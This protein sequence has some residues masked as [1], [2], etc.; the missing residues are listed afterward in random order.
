MSRSLKNSFWLALLVGVGFSAQGSGVWTKPGGGSWPVTGNWL[1]GTVAAGSGS[2]AD[3]STLVLS[4]SPTVTLDGNR[5]IGV[6]I[7]GDVGNTYGW[8]LNPGTGGILTLSG[9]SPTITVSN[10]TTLLNVALDGTNGLTKTGLGRLRLGVSNTLGGAVVVN[11]GTLTFGSL[12]L[13]SDLSSGAARV[14]TL[15]LATGGVVQ[16]SGTLALDASTGLNPCVQ[17]AGSGVLQLTSTNNSAT[18]PDISFGDSDLPNSTAN[19]GSRIAVNVDLGSTQRY[20]W[21]RTGHNGVGKYGVGA[22]DCQFA[23]SIFGSGGLTFIAQGNFMGTPAMETPLCLNGSNSFAGPLEIRRGSVYLGHPQAL[24]QTNSLLL[25]PSGTDNARFFLYGNHTTIA[26]L[27]SSATGTAVI[28]NGNEKT[29]A[30]LTLGAATLTVWQNHPGVYWGAVQDVLPEYDGSGS[31]TTGPLS[32]LKAGPATLTLAG[33]GT[34]TGS[35]A[36]NGGKLYVNSTFSGLVA[37]TVASG[38]VLGGNG[39]V[40]AP[41]AVANGA[42]LEAGNG[43]A[44]GLLTLDSLKLGANAGDTTHVDFNTNPGGLAAINVLSANGLSVNGTATVNLIGSL[45]AVYPAT[46]PLIAYSGSPQ[47]GGMFVLG[48]MSSGVVAYVTNNPAASAIQLVVSSI[49][50]PSVTWVGTPTNSWDRTGK[51]VWR[52][53]GTSVPTAYADGNEVIF[54][55]TAAQFGINLPGIVAPASIII[56]NSAHDFSLSGAGG[57]TGFTRLVK[58]GSAKL[59]LGGSNNFSGGTILSSGTLALGGAQ[60]ILGA[61]V[62]NGRLD[63][64][65]FDTSLPDLSGTGM[66]DNSAPVTTSLLTLN[67]ATNVVFNGSIQ[68]SAGGLALTVTGGGS[69]TLNGQNTFSGPTMVKGASLV[70]NGSLA[71]DLSVQNTSTI[72]GSGRVYGAM[73]L[74][75]GSSLKVGTSGPLN[76]GPMILKGPITV[77]VSGTVSTTNAGTYLLLNH[78]ALGGPGS[79]VLRP[80]PGFSGGAFVASLQDTNNQLTLVVAP[81]KTTGTLADVRHVV[82]FMQENRSFDHYFGTLHG[83]RGFNDRAALRQPN[84]SNVFWQPNGSGFVLPF[85]TSISCL[86]DLAHDWASSHQA[87]NNGLWNQWVS[88]KGSE[89]MAYLNRADLPYYYALADAYTVCDEYHCSIHA[90]TNPNRLYLMTGMV[91]PNGYGGGPVV[92]NREPVPGFNWTTYPERLQQAGV[93]WRVYQAAD[94]FD[95]NALAWF[96][97]FQQAGPGN[98]LYDRGISTVADLVAG[99]AAD[100]TNNN[101]PTVS[102]I[103]A[104]TAASE[105]PSASPA[106]G[107]ALTKQLLDA[108]AANPA[109]YNSTVFILNYDENDGFFDHGT[110]ISP[111]A[112]T[113]DEFVTSQ[114]IGLGPRVPA[115]IVS[116]WTRGGYVCSQV[117]DHTSVLKFLERVTGVAEPNLSA[118]RRQ[119]CGDLTSAFDFAH[120]DPS[121]PSLVAMTPINCGGGTT[122]V[123]PAQQS[124]P[125]QEPGTLT[126]RPLP[127]QPNTVSRSDCVGGTFSITLT[128][129]GSESTHFVIYPNAYRSDGPWSF[130]VSPGTSTNAVFS[131]VSSGGNYDFTCYGP[132]GF[133]RAFAGNSTLDCAREEAIPILKPFTM[134]FGMVL[135]NASS[136]LVRFGVTNGYSANGWLAF[137]VAPATSTVV[138]IPSQNDGG[139]YDLTVTNGADAS[140]VRRFAGHVEVGAAPPAL[141]SSSVSPT[142]G[143]TIITYPVSP[144]YHYLLQRTTRLTAPARWVNVSSNSP[145]ANGVFQARDNFSDLPVPPPAAYYRLII[146]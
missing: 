84:G 15:N 106:S 66:V 24:T 31:G 52:Q 17:I 94:N 25:N 79:F 71:G 70:I 16:S 20:L 133:L 44:L 95:D 104:S 103:I 74:A 14:L 29:G 145:T 7:F 32:L 125:T 92:D 130:E 111:P 36:V 27:T 102:W 13:A 43:S 26:D 117:F 4:S 63:L 141:S 59:T 40:N 23:G 88:A 60:A 67:S 98:P 64:A 97:V 139:R 87:W 6:L 10:Q 99:F 101:L 142:I 39:T 35:L 100:V 136:A 131:T 137:D 82:V 118:W 61:M 96:S 109:V 89:T 1:N 5:T 72:G 129:S 110:P 53:T 73:T 19:W 28:A 50:V 134:G 3:F 123:P 126:A 83:V 37:V 135:S 108:L 58:Q 65:G 114:P 91:D 75:A 144:Y 12:T 69:F 42:G 85:H 78:G 9:A 138:M 11:A 33:P 46:Y 122:A 77:A 132:N 30:S 76:T 93:S 56:S 140:F 55:D 90:S 119:V 120:P 22:A 124:L 45:P 146:D 54:N 2:T 143:G 107:E 128:N 127:Y 48:T 115:I 80:I 86:T 81:F 68:S 47:P 116:P 38:A 8:T 105:H 18:S 113:P 51:A 57:I 112:G 62:V 34:F 21:G 49:A 121:Y 41:V